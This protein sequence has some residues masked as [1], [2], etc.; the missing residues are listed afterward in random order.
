MSVEYT[1]EKLFVESFLIG[2]PTAIQR[3]PPH[4]ISFTLSIIV[5]L[6]FNVVA[7]TVSTQ[8]TPFVDTIIVE[9]VPDPTAIQLFPFHAI[10]FTLETLVSVSDIPVQIIASV[11]TAIEKVVAVDDG[12]FVVLPSPPIIHFSPFHIIAL[13]TPS[14]GIFSPGICFQLTPSFDVATFDPFSS[15]PTATHTIPFHTA[16][17]HTPPLNA[18]FPIS[19]PNSAIMY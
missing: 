9:T 6:P 13:M 10:R 4:T 5:L 11:E 17:L 1:I 2:F 12:G 19:V 7:L 15:I 18:V 8:S 16:S 3:F 14:I